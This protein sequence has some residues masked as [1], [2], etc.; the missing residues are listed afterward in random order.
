MQQERK[1]RNGGGSTSSILVATIIA[2]VAARPSRLIGNP[3][4]STRNLSNRF[5]ATP[6]VCHLR[7]CNSLRC[8]SHSTAS[9]LSFASMAHPR[10][11]VSCP[12]Q[13][14]I[15][16][17]PSETNSVKASA[18]D[19]LFRPSTTVCP[20]HSAFERAGECDWSNNVSTHSSLQRSSVKSMMPTSTCGAP[21]RDNLGS[22]ASE[23]TPTYPVL[24][25]SPTSYTI[26]YSPR[27]GSEE[28][29]TAAFFSF[30]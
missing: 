30:Q 4:L 6:N 2:A 8:C 10:C 23:L 25:Y 17:E 20:V 3:K 24:R 9:A 13:W 11:A 18:W 29:R 1:E 22:S 21:I 15:C 14:L 26:T 16:F 5:T 28:V 7:E 19:T 12:T 27:F